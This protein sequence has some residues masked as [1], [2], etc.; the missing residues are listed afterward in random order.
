MSNGMVRSLTIFRRPNKVY[1]NDRREIPIHNEFDRQYGTTQRYYHC[2]FFTC[3]WTLPKVLSNRRPK[4][5]KQLTEWIMIVFTL[6]LV[7]T[8]LHL[9][10]TFRSTKAT[11]LTLSDCFVVLAWLSNLSLAICDS[12]LYQYGWMPPLWTVAPGKET[13][14]LKILFFENCTYLNVMY[15][16]KISMLAQFNMWIP[17]CMKWSRLVLKIAWILTIF[18]WIS[19]FLMN[20]LA[21]WPLERNWCASSCTYSCLI[22]LR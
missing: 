5:T 8:L 2:K 19:E 7:L 10:S 17:Q 18:A 13:M 21:C 20:L 4:L 22:Y 15:C 9:R 1:L 3:Q 11:M 12:L 6:A 14:S 16:V